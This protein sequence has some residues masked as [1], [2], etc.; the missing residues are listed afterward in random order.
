MAGLAK[1]KWMHS[2]NKEM[3]RTAA[4]YQKPYG[5][6]AVSVTGAQEEVELWDLFFEMY[7]KAMEQ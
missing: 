1:R 4:R 3:T 2:S 6:A 7:Q 5:L